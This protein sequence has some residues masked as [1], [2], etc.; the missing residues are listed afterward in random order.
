MLVRCLG[1]VAVWL[2]VFLCLSSSV[3]GQD[4]R[5]SLQADVARAIA[6]TAFDARVFGEIA[7]LPVDEQ[8]AV[9]GTFAQAAN[10]RMRQQAVAALIPIGPDQ[11]EA[12][13]RGFAD[14]SVDEVRMLALAFLYLKADDMKAKEQFLP[15]LSSAKLL[16]AMAAVRSLARFPDEDEANERLATVLLST[17]C[18]AYARF[19][20]MVAIGTSRNRALLPTLF[21]LLDDPTPLRRTQDDTSRF[22]DYAAQT[23]ERIYEVHRLPMNA[24]YQGELAVRDA[25]IAKWQAW[26][27]EQTDVMTADPKASVTADTVEHAM[28]VFAGEGGDRKTAR[29]SMQ[30]AFSGHLCLGHLP[31]ID[32]VIL[33]S[34]RDLTRVLSVLGD[35]R[36][37]AEVRPWSDLD[38]RLLREFLPAH[39]GLMA[40]LPDAQAAAFIQFVVEN[41]KKTGDPFPDDWAWSFCRSFPEVFPDSP[42]REEVAGYG[43]RISERTQL[44]GMRIMLHGTI[45]ELEPIPQEA[46]T[47]KA[48][49]AIQI[50]FGAAAQRVSNEPSNWER[51]RAAVDCLVKSCATRRNKGEE[52]KPFGVFERQQIQQYPASEFPLLGEAAA[53][54]RVW[55]DPATALEYADKAKTLNPGNPKVLAIRG[56]ILLELDPPQTEDAF[57]ALWQAFE[58]APESLAGEPESD[59]AVTFLLGEIR[60][61]QGEEAYQEAKAKTRN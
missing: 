55:S 34:I 23:I 51:Y 39:P 49:G 48:G 17:E 1:R 20:A 36:R 5:Q 43:R 22:C 7:K 24:Y 46:T 58:L 29:D 40:A 4:G 2:P 15:G 60:K 37:N 52:V 19:E 59:Q 21:Q 26:G 33:P 38:L 9:L 61:R 53:Y 3:R 10:I 25:A 27:R 18:I 28:A 12:A 41:P 6:D 11:A 47:P 57:L 44:R 30:L 8:V 45:P 16:T 56:I 35:D 31:G 32:W 13:V 42:R 14:D 54:L 50:G